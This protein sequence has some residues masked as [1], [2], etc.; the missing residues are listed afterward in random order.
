MKTLKNIGIILGSL[1][2]TICL[3]LDI[4][5][6]I[7]YKTAPDK[8]VSWTFKV[9]NQEVVDAKTGVTT[10]KH[11]CE[12]NVFDDVYEIKFN[13]LQDEEKN[14]FYSQGF[15]F[16][17]TGEEN[18]VDFDN[19]KFSNVLKTNLVGSSGWFGVNKTY[20]RILSGVNF[21]NMKVLNY[22]SDGNKDFES[23]NKISGEYKFKIEIGEDI[24]ILQ[25]KNDD[26]DCSLN[27]S[28][29]LQTTTKTMI[30]KNTYN[31]YRASDVYM[32]AELLYRSIENSTILN[33]E[34]TEI[35][36]EF[37]DLFKYF[38]YDENSKQYTEISANSDSKVIADIKSYYSIL[39]TKNEGNITSSEQSLFKMVDGNSNFKTENAVETDYFTGTTLLKVDEMDFDWIETDNSGEYKFKLSEDFKKIYGESNSKK[40]QL[41]ICIDSD[42]LNSEYGVKFVGFEEDAFDNFNIYKIVEKSNGK[43][44]EV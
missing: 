10:D 30:V 43:T 31:E 33:G 19:K 22:A 15:Q 40:L 17:A 5:F 3:G 2:L 11:F 44:Q 25:F 9:G 36:F 6:A 26:I 16:I 23:S 27:N 37:G 29:F 41:Y 39:V 4:W 38:K 20:D 32:F 7:L 14:S 12:I 28:N 34:T 13:Y 1:I 21:E 18:K 35:I 8:V 42:K 24:Y